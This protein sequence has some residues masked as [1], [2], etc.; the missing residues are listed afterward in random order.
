MIFRDFSTTGDG[1]V[2]A[3]QI[4]RIMAETG[5]PLSELKKCLVKYPQAQRNMKVR[6]KRA[7]EQMPEVLKLV[8]EAEG[9]LAGAGRVLL[10][11]SGTEPKIRLLIEGRDGER[12]NAQADKIAGVIQE[13]IG[14]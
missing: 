11:Y 3:L 8:A 13:A 6:E 7:L 2:S 10:R 9:E 1:I 5:K 12:I 4:L 14:A